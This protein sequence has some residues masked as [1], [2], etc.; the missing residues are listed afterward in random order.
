MNTFIFY[1]LIVYGLCFLI[2]CGLSIYILFHLK[3]N[4]ALTGNYD[5]DKSYIY[6]LAFFITFSPITLPLALYNFIKDGGF[7]YGN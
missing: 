4:K 2:A 1:F 6:N 5:T 7:T 3:K